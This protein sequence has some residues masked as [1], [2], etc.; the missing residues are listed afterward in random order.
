MCSLLPFPLV[1]SVV[2]K[3][4]EKWDY[5][6]LCERAREGE[7]E[8]GRERGREGER[9]EKE[10]QENKKKGQKRKGGIG[11]NATGRNFLSS[12]SFLSLPFCL[13]PSASSPF[14][15]PFPLPFFSRMS[16]R[17]KVGGSN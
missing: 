14:L 7:G 8:R 9:G 2:Y 12:F 5:V 16:G 17:A 15:F 3:D 4:E 6:K 1:V 13:F 11:K 10:D